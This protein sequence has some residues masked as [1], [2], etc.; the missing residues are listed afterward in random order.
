VLQRLIAADLK[1]MAGFH[2]L[3]QVTLL[4]PQKPEAAGYPWGE[5]RGKKPRVDYWSLENPTG[6][7]SIGGA[8]G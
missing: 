2:R 8:G 5:G 7:H 1:E 3:V 4:T 6:A